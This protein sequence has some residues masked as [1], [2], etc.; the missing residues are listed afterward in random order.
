MSF[1]NLIEM[2][3]LAEL[4]GQRVSLQAIRTM[5][6]KARQ[7]LGTEHPFA[8]EQFH[9]DGKTIWLETRDV[10]HDRGLIDLMSGNGAMFEVLEGSFRKSL[11]FG[12]ADGL[13]KSWRPSAD[14]PRVVIDPTRRFGRPIDGETGVPT[15]ILSEALWTAQ[16]DV[17]RVAKDWEV[18]ENAVREAAAFELRYGKRMAA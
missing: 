11:K 1:V 5:L 14:E 4:R 15:E 18:P 2:R 8:C 3:F 6:D 12:D 16:G 9:T 17:A 13:V 10:T 7:K